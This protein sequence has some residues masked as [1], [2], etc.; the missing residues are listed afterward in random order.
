MLTKGLNRDVDPINQPKATS[1]Y[2]LNGNLTD[3]F[4]AITNE[5]S[6]SLFSQL[7]LAYTVI[8]S[9]NLNNDEKIIFCVAVTDTTG[10]IGLLKNDGVVSWFGSALN[11]YNFKRQHQI[12][13]TYKVNN[14]GERVVY[15]T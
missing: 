8:G 7:P 11:I 14:K 10:R 1:P 6:T 9:I 13:G 15:W 2:I 5:H 3:E 12:E 4:G